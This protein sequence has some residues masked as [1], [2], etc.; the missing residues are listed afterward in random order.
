MREVNSSINRLLDNI[1]RFISKFYFYRFLRGILFYFTLLLGTIFL[2]FLLDY[3]FYL[4][5]SVR[6]VLVYLVIIGGGL[7]VIYFLVIPLLQYF[8]IISGF[9]HNEA[10]YLISNRFNG[11]YD[12]LINTVELHRGK[13]NTFYSKDLLNA[14]IDQRAQYLNTFNFAQSIHLKELSAFFRIFFVVTLVLVIT[15]FVQPSFFNQG[16]KH[17]IHFNQS[18]DN[19]TFYTYELVTDSLTVG[20]GDDFTVEVSLKGDYLPDNLYMQAGGND[21]LMKQ[22]AKDTYTYTFKSLNQSLDLYFTNGNNRSKTYTI[23]V[24]PK[25]SII[26]F[27]VRVDNPGYTGNEDFEKVNVGDLEIPEG[28]NVSWNFKANNADSVFITLS[29]STYHV[30]KDG[31]RFKFNK[32]LYE[33]ATYSITLKNKNFCK[34]NF[35]TYKIDVEPDAYP[36]IRVEKQ[37]DS[38]NFNQFYFHG[39]ISDD[40]GFESLKFKIDGGERSVLDTSFSI[41]INKNIN[42][43]D[44]YYS[45]DFSSFSDKQENI[46]YYFEVHDNDR[47][48][49]P[50]SSRSRIFS[51]SKKSQRQIDS[52]SNEKNRRIS[53]NLSQGMKIAKELQNDLNELRRE[54]LS[55][56]MSSWEKNQLVKNIQKKQKKLE[57]ILEE[58][59]EKSKEKRNLQ[60][61]SDNKDKELA[62]KQKKLEKLMENLLSEDLKELLKDISELQ[63]KFNKDK[64]NKMKKDMELSYE[65][66]EK[67]LDRNL[68]LMNKLQVEENLNSISDQLDELSN[69]QEELSKNNAKEDISSDSLKKEQQNL[70]KQFNDI[71]QKYDKTLEK[72]DKLEYPYKLEDFQK[73][74]DNISNQF[75]NIEKKINEGNFS[76]GEDLQKDNAEKMKR[77]SKSMSSMIEKNQAEKLN[78]NRDE[79]R[80]LMNDLLTFS[81]DNEDNFDD[82]NTIS[83]ND[84]KYIDLLKQQKDLQRDFQVINDSLY[85]LSKQSFKLGQPIN[86]QLLTINKNFDRLLSAMEEREIGDARTRQQYVVTASNELTLILSEILNNLRNRSMS[87]KDGKGNKRKNAQGKPS[88][89]DLRK[90]QKSI[91]SQLEKILKQMKEKGG[92]SQQLSEKLAETLSEQEKFQQKLRKLQ[93]NTGKGNAYQ[94]VLQKIQEMTEQV[95]EDIIRR[96][97]DQ[98]TIQKQNNIENKL[99]EA[100]DADRQRKKSKERKA[101]TANNIPMSNPEKV[102]PYRQQN[103]NYIERLHYDKIRLQDYY[104]K[105]YN[106][107]IQKIG[108]WETD[109]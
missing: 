12:K 99:L 8:G 57:R 91:K 43:Q 21:I 93:Q 49:S 34:K 27:I 3:F 92:D 75:D 36:E 84:P 18:F 51:F 55:K 40:Y 77:L 66:M 56:N 38:S 11:I 65:D 47:V 44:F 33:S 86:E 6:T 106:S 72:N 25:P 10:S 73:Q 105:K 101:K 59:K 104:E 29:D 45:F 30:T 85:A 1:D 41:P 31:R 39:N 7:G 102:F 94:K 78:K 26:D 89:S 13:G 23:K 62:E 35:I 87:Q 52:L 9:S 88:I 46:K 67:Q 22:N 20:K 80:R 32:T 19:D 70:R 15:F 90:G 60:N 96:S 97:I 109:E 42:Y 14:A 69:K 4:S 103:D 28:A 82:L 37:R 71:S 54:N 61:L 98:E 100:E 17:F 74:R 64:F 81:F 50:K 107:F 63:N 16:T 108:Q 53:E 68:E 48:N 83:P 79:L 5:A 76:E 2:L 95:N 24:L 58:S